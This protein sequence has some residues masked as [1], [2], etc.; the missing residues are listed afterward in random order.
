MK[1]RYVIPA[2]AIAFTVAATIAS[3][4][5]AQNFS[6]TLPSVT[7]SD[8]FDTGSD[9]AKACVFNCKADK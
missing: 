8:E 4:T 9:R 7:F 3:Q 1:T 2:F 5:Q 6:S